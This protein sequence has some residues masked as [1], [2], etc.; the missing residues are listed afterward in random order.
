MNQLRRHALSDEQ[1]AKIEGLFPP[2]D[3]A[4][5]QW[6][7]HRLMMDGILWVMN[8]GA[9]WRDLPER[10]GPWQTVY[11]R[12]RR[13]TRAGLFS[14]IVAELQTDLD[15]AGLIDW[16]LFCVD[17]T[18]IRAH[19]AAAGAQK[20]LSS[21]AS[22]KAT[23]LAAHEAVSLRKSIWSSTGRAFRSPR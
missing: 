3:I 9:P 17:G 16:D 10:F 15:E 7:N 2:Y 1:W 6:K 23:P 4:G 11:S 18:N 8:T 21:Q 5:G 22:L 13:W 20:K 19:K 12:F 14:R